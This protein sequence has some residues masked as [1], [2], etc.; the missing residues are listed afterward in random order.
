VIT[1]SMLDVYHKSNYQDFQRLQPAD[2]AIGGDVEA[3]LP[4]FI[5]AIRARLRASAKRVR[6]AADGR[7]EDAPRD[8]GARQGSRGGGLGCEPRQHRALAAE[9]WNVIKNEK[10]ALPVS[11][12]ISWARRLWPVTEHY[13]MLGGNGA[14]GPRRLC[15]DRTGRRTR[16]QGPGHTNG[17]IPVGRRHD[18]RAGV[19][20][21]RRRI[22]KSRSSW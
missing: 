13:Q 1:I 4:D 18:V 22:T 15:A 17:R 19:A 10:W 7:R 14:A 20:A 11:T 9:M 21:G 2:L 5:E 3:S 12:R 6:R 8:E 16:E